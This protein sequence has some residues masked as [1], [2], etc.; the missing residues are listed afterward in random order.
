[1]P[2]TQFQIGPIQIQRDQTTQELYSEILEIGAL[3][4]LPLI[5]AL[6]L[7]FLQISLLLDL[8]SVGD[9]REYNP[10]IPPIKQAYLQNDL[11]SNI[12]ALIMA[13]TSIKIKI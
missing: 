10:L 9:I 12:I 6:L 3:N 5:H 8:N 1:M 2:T 11:L 13:A 7:H 4:Y